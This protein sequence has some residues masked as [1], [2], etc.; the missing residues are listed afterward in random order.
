MNVKIRFTLAAAVA[1]ALATTAA[2]AA[3]A[4]KTVT[5][6]LIPLQIVRITSPS[7]A[8]IRAIAIRP[9]VHP[10]KDGKCAVW[11]AVYSD[12]PAVADGPMPHIR[13]SLIGQDGQRGQRIAVETNYTGVYRAVV[14]VGVW[15]EA[16][17]DV[18]TLPF[19]V[20]PTR[21]RIECD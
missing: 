2:V 19:G 10:L 5:G 14:P 1:L 12:N 13:T 7:M 9:V 20:H 21:P 11:G 17:P 15:R 18:G 3:P 16:R 6:S 8:M 4:Q